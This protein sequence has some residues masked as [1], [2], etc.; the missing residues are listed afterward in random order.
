MTVEPAAFPNVR[1]EEAFRRTARVARRGLFPSED[2]NELFRRYR[3]SEAQLP[4]IIAALSANPSIVQTFLEADP[5]IEE[6]FRPSA[7]Y[8]ELDEDPD[9]GSRKLFGVIR[10]R[11]SPDRALEVLHDFDRAW[12]LKKGPRIWEAMNFTVEIEDDESL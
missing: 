11:M 6:M 4:A 2:I 9:G 5:V 8:L 1:D 12:F 7:K 3:G 10:V